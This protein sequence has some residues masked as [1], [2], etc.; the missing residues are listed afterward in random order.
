MLILSAS[1]IWVI[2][3][4][5]DEVCLVVEHFTHDSLQFCS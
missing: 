5:A 1:Y 4:A 3:I 2:L